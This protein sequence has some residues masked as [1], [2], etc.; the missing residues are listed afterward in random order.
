MFLGIRV[1]ERMLVCDEELTIERRHEDGMYKDRLKREI[2]CT[3][4]RMFDDSCTVSCTGF[5][6]ESLISVHL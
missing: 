2:K 4:G 3:K 1:A 5:S 6:K